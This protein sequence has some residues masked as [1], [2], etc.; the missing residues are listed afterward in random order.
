MTPK[1]I[2]DDALIISRRIYEWEI[3]L[4]DYYDYSGAKQKIAVNRWLNECELIM[5]KG[6]AQSNLRAGY[7][8][9]G[10]SRNV[11]DIGFTAEE[12]KEIYAKQILRMSGK[13][14]ANARLLRN[15]LAFSLGDGGYQE[16]YSQYS[17][18][19]KGNLGLSLRQKKK[20]FLKNTVYNDAVFFIDKLG[21]EWKPDRYAEMVVRTRSRE[22]ED[23]VMAEEMKEVGLDVVQISDANTT[24][25]MCLQFEG[26][27]FSRFGDTPELPRLEIY[28]PFHPNCRHRMLP[29][30]DYNKSMG[31]VN[32]LKNSQESIKAEKWTDA[33]KKAIN[34]QEDWNRE[35]R[36][37]I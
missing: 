12:Y 16:L 24:T 15:S 9:F 14:L 5:G 4:L 1:V 2:T 8:G 3:D 7:S 32:K 35:N 23:I 36:T 17:D 6:M 33:Q 19:S 27:Y 20:I 11:A 21:R 28:P 26:K 30:R 29:Q 18:F 37:D 31:K 13:D 25:P 10:I 34:K 22:V